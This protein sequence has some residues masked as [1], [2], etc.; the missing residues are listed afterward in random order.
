LLR[1]L[2]AFFDWDL[3]LY[4][5]F[6]TKVESKVSV[7]GL[8]H[9]Q[10]N[11]WIEFPAKYFTIRLQQPLTNLLKQAPNGHYGQIIF[12]RLFEF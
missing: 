1:A 4:L 9:L 6:F 10:H 2:Q 7:L 5:M 11:P 3:G 12:S 8:N